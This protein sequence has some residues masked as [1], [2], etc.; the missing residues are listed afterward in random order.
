MLPSAPTAPVWNGLALRADNIFATRTWA[1]CWWRQYGDGATPMV[2]TDREDDPR[3]VVPLYSSG[4]LLRQVRLIGNGPADHLGPACAPEHRHLAAQLLRDRFLDQKRPDWDVLLLQDVPEQDGWPTLLGGTEVRRTDSPS[5][6]FEQGGTWDDF[7]KSK[8]KNFREQAGRKRRRLE[9]EFAAVFRTAT[10]DSVEEDLQTL[11]R[12]HRLRWGADAPF[13]TGRERALHE[14]FAPRALAEGWLRL[15]VLELDGEPAAA[16]YNLRFGSV[17]GSY[18]G[19][20]DP[21]FDEHSVGFVLYTHSIR[22][23]LESGLSEFRMLRGDESYKSRFAN[24]TD[25]V[26]SLALPGTV[27]GRAA[28]T[29]TRLRRTA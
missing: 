13:A 27:R 4:R 6:T 19:G 3:V 10:A 14:E 26:H 1:E 17:E 9:R 23:A 15:H 25:V 12:L 21:R 18:Q 16:L 7:L 5:L 24:R 11:F 22:D 28:I 2:L 8:S 29:G 20:R